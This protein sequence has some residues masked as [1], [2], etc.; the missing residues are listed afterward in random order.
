[1][2]ALDLYVGTIEQKGIIADAIWKWYSYNKEQRLFA[3]KV[4]WIIRRNVYVK[5]LYPALEYLFGAP[6]FP[7]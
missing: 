2:R 7:V 4:W 5:D 3:L 6:T 1:M